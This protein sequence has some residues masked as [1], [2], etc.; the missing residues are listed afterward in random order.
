MQQPPAATF[1]FQQMRFSPIPL[2][3]VP[4]V[5][6]GADRGSTARCASVDPPAKAAT[7]PVSSPRSRGCTEQPPW[8]W[9]TTPCVTLSVTLRLGTNPPCAASVALLRSAHLHH[10]FY[11]RS[12]VFLL[13]P[14]YSSRSKS[15]VFFTT[16]RL[17]WQEQMRRRIIH[18]S[19][20]REPLTILLIASIETNISNGFYTCM[21]G[22]G[23]Q[24]VDIPLYKN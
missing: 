15:P 5:A 3:K 12:P 14:D 23:A 9:I 18:L 17:Q 8:T 7:P 2:A 13:L 6:R 10:R 11:L 16:T 19:L 24:V 21:N 4:R 1:Q 20:S 22:L